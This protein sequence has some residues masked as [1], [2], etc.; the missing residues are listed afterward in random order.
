MDSHVQFVPGSLARLLEFLHEQPDSNDLLQG[1]LL[2]D[3]LK[4]LSSHFSPVWSN[5][6]YGQ[7]AADERAADVNAA[8]FEIGM[9]GLGVFA[10]RRAA[11]PGFNPRFSGFGGEEGYIHEKIRRRRRPRLYACPSCAGPTALIARSALLIARFGGSASATICSATPNCGSTR[12]RSKNISRASSVSR[13][14]RRSLPPQAR[15]RRSVP[16]FRRPLFH[17]PRRQPRA[18]E[19]ARPRCQNPV[20][21]RAGDA[22]LQLTSA[23]RSPTAA[24]SKK[25]RRQK[26]ANLLVFDAGFRSLRIRAR[27]VPRALWSA[28]G[29]FPGQ[30]TACPAPWLTTPMS[31]AAC[32]SELPE[33]PSGIALWMKQRPQPGFSSR[34]HRASL[35]ADPGGGH[36]NSEGFQVSSVRPSYRR[37]DRLPGR[38][39]PFLIAICCPGYRAPPPILKWPTSFSGS[40]KSKD[41]QGFDAYAGDRLTRLR[42]RSACDL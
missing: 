6:M 35:P 42:R 2:Q 38:L 7:W 3:D 11:W 34:G 25:R 27:T 12:S 20:R 39:K 15:D 36:M 41:G 5:G 18:V 23:R 13:R 4:R 22:V 1:P 37:A 30:F 40:Y 8:P 19:C 31:S 32:C 28:S 21:A 9:Q 16:L 14:P 26:L 29:R 33:T 17:P 24:S 10:C